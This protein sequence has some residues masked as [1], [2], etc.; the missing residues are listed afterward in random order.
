MQAVGCPR[1][2]QACGGPLNLE[3]WTTDRDPAF[4]IHITSQLSFGSTTDRLPTLISP[5]KELAE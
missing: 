2:M 5:G 4:L 3:K 1:V